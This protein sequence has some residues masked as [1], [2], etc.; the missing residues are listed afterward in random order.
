MLSLKEQFE[1]KQGVWSKYNSLDLFARSEKLREIAN[2]VDLNKVNLNA[3][4]QALI[5]EIENMCCFPIMDEEEFLR[6]WKLNNWTM[7]KDRKSVV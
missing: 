4:G 1:S 3:K 6:V 7:E 2:K 5:S